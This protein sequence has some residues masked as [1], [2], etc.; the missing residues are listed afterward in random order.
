MARVKQQHLNQYFSP[1]ADPEAAGAPAGDER[2]CGGAQA[3]GRQENGRLA[4]EAPGQSLPVY[5][6]R[7]HEGTE[8]EARFL[9]VCSQSQGSRDGHLSLNLSGN[10]R[11]A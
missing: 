8:S 11:K 10:G 6:H 3:T 2:M 7:K 4:G 1:G 5:A 9:R